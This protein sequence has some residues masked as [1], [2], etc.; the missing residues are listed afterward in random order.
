M[1]NDDND[2]QWQ[3]APVVT[4]GAH[5]P[6]HALRQVTWVSASH[7]RA[8]L[9]QVD[10]HPGLAVAT[11]RILQDDRGPWLSRPQD[12]LGLAGT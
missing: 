6:S 8:S 10:A 7:E 4:K 5:F 12:V 1:T 9:F 2:D 3:I 11:R